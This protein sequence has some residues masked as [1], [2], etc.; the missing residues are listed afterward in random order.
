MKKSIALPAETY[1]AVLN[2]LAARPYREVAQLLGRMG[3]EAKAVDVPPPPTEQKTDE[4]E[5][6]GRE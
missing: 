4:S 6:E 5:T 3:V 2:Y 1:T